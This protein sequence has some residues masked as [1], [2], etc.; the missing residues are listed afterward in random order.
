MEGNNCAQLIAGLEELRLNGRGILSALDSLREAAS[1][2]GPVPRDGLLQ[3]VDLAWQ[4]AA[5]EDAVG[6]RVLVGEALDQPQL[7]SMYAL[8]EGLSKEA[9]RYLRGDGLGI[10]A[11]R[12]PCTEY[13]TITKL[14]ARC[15]I[16]KFLAEVSDGVK[17]PHYC[18]MVESVEHKKR[19]GCVYFPLT[20]RATLAHALNVCRLVETA[21][22]REGKAFAIYRAICQRYPIK[23]PGL[24]HN[25]ALQIYRDCWTLYE[26]HGARIR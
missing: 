1:D 11:A 25:Q 5:R 7:V 2:L 8:I 12:L 18:L 10:N 14:Q 6:V 20:Q 9:S 19:V 13:A 24:T 4:E 3:L 26:K 16:E 22:P 15:V 17:V 23:A 21:V